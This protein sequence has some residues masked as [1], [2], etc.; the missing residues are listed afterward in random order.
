MLQ[1]LGF[2]LKGKKMYPKHKDFLYF[3]QMMTTD[4]QNALIA[5]CN[6]KQLV[7]TSSKAVFV[8]LPSWGVLQCGLGLIGNRQLFLQKMVAIMRVQFLMHV[9]TEIILLLKI[10]HRS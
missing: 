1:D 10:D 6:K 2:H 3:I 8:S 9:N 5:L 7:A 4:V